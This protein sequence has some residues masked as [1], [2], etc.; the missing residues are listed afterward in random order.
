MKL[1]KI[2]AIVATTALGLPTLAHAE[3]NVSIY[4]LIDINLSYEKAGGQKFTGV[5]GSELNGSRLGFKG[6]E[7]LG[8]GL[9]ALFVL[10][11]GFD[12][13]TGATGQGGRQ[14]GRQSFVGLEGSWGKVMLGRQYSPAF[15][16]LDP[17]EATGGADRTAGLLHRKTGSVARGYETRFDNMIKYRS[18]S[19]G[20]FSADVG[21]WTGKENTGPNDDARKEGRGYGITGMYKN[22]PFAIAVTTQS[23]FTN[24]TGGKAST[25]GIAGAYD[26]QVAKAYLLYTQD[27]ESGSQG[28]GKARSYALG[29]EIPVSAAGT[30][31]VSYGARDES[32]EANTEDAHGWSVYYMHGLSKRTTLYTAYSHISNKGDANYGWN[33]TPA[34]GDDPSVVMAGIRHRF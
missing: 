26:F 18:P 21:Y 30:V 25:H 5:A 10:E 4:G 23:V 27:R 1:N 32:N 7:D 11:T 29:A 14:F 6:T 33:M 17:Y 9:K 31:A 28:K 22:G 16:A 2:A 3:T 20:G 34:A 19:F 13:D 24:A 15:V 8:N 12:P